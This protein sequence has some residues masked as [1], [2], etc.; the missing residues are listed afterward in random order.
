MRLKL[1]AALAFFVAVSTASAVPVAP[2]ASLIKGIV[3]G[4]EAISSTL[5]GMQPEQTIY[6][7]TIRI[8]SSEDV[9]EMPNFLKG[10]QEKDMAFYSKKALSPTILKK[11]I[12]ARVFYRGDERGGQWWIQE[13]QILD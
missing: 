5:L 3:L 8:E 2:N 9:G 7:L 4:C 1:C 13:I 10:T 11:K 6:R 12:K